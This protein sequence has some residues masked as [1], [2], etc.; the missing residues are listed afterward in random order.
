MISTGGGAGQFVTVTASSDDVTQVAAPT[1][2]YTSPSSVG[3]LTLRVNGPATITVTVSNGQATNG[4]LSRS[5]RV[6]RSLA[7]TAGRGRAAPVIYPN[8]SMGGRCWVQLPGGQ[9]AI[10]RLTDAAGRLVLTQKLP[11]G[12]A[13]AEVALPAGLAQGT[14]LA[15][16][17]SKD[18]VYRQRLVVGP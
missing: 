12:T 15:S 7:A 17:S 18:E 8:P 9:P 6:V 10:L 14:H 11:G 2:N 3:S 4:S 1:V 16:L 13:P 5:F